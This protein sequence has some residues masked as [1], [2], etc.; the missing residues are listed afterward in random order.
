[1]LHAPAHA[2]A[3]AF[4][5]V[6]G[7]SEPWG[8]VSGPEWLRCVYVTLDTCVFKCSAAGD[9]HL[10]TQHACTYPEPIH[11]VGL[12]TNPAGTPC[13]LLCSHPATLHPLVVAPEPS[14]IYMVCCDRCG[15]AAGDM[16]LC[17]CSRPS[18]RHGCCRL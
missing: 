6:P 1:M 10:C 2:Y 11:L 5:P 16:L 17:A 15:E 7:V 14:F 9:D 3:A 8:G 4:H 12:I 18:T 13:R